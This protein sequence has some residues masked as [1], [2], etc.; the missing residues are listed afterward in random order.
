VQVVDNVGAVHAFDA[1]G[2]A[3]VERVFKG[4]FYDSRIDLVRARCAQSA[5][6]TPESLLVRHLACRHATHVEPPRN[7]SMLRAGFDRATYEIRR[8]P[9]SQI[10]TFLML[11]ASGVVKRTRPVSLIVCASCW[12]PWK[13]MK[14]LFGLSVKESAAAHL[15]VHGFWYMIS[16]TGLALGVCTMVT[17]GC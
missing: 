15:D 3:G 16:S 2:H 9:S 13:T 12:S 6:F 11:M 5:F 17:A 8:L 7:I 14:R 1:L 4:P 10:L